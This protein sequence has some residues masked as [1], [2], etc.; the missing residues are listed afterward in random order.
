MNRLLEMKVSCQNKTRAAQL[1][2]GDTGNKIEIKP[3]HT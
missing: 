2:Q 1:L 3:A